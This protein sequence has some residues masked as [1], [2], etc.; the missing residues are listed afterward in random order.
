[1]FGLNGSV[2]VVVV[3]GNVVGAIVVGANVVG[4]NVVGA[5][6][7][8][9][10]VV[11]GNVVG[12]VVV[13]VVSGLQRSG[14]M[15]QSTSS[16]DRWKTVCWVFV[17]SRLVCSSTSWATTANNEDATKNVLMLIGIGIFPVLSR[18]TE[19]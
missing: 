13:V 3:G 12:A 15:K 17:W 5:I 16:W 19:T 6:V 4:G 18:R 1:V 14:A 11:G 2:V 9:G 10:I 8:G 7:V